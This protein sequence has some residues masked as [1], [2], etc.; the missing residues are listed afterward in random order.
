MFD[1]LKNKNLYIVRQTTKADE[2]ATVLPALEEI[3]SSFK[4]TSV[5]PTAFKVYS[6]SKL[7]FSIGYPAEENVLSGAVQNGVRIE[8]L[9]ANRSDNYKTA[10]G[11]FYIEV[12]TQAG[13]IDC[14]P[15]FSST[16]KVVVDGVEGLRGPASPG[17]Y[18][19]YRYLLC[20]NRAGKNYLVSVTEGDDRQ[21]RPKSIL[22]SF[23][24]LAL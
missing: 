13:T 24:F 3:L 1:F 16:R 10:P 22:D 9:P 23:K 20:F 7:G 18:N 8:N 4:I 6:D 12:Y 5:E 2:E 17:P 21:D 14:A 15:M 19:G 11:D